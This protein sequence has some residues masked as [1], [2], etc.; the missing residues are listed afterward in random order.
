MTTLK[1]AGTTDPRVVLGL[2]GF[3]V[4]AGSA[5]MFVKLLVGEIT[6][7]QLVAGRVAIASVP[8]LVLMAI[9]GSMPKL[10]RPFLAG[11]MLLAI[12]DT[13]GPYLL[14]SWS[15][16]H[17]S[18][19]TAALVVSTMPLFTT[20]IASSTA[21]DEGMSSGA[22]LG[23]ASGFLGVGVLAG[24]EA[25][26]VTSNSALAVFAVLF[27][28]LC[29]AVGAVYSRTLLRLADPL[30]LSAVKL[31]L[32][33]FMLLPATAATDGLGAFESLSRA[34]WLG[35]ITVGFVSTGIG[36]CVYQW[37][38][39]RAGSVRA[40]L[41][42]YIVPVVALLFGWVFLDEPAG[43]ATLA[44]AVLIIVGVALVMFGPQLKSLARSAGSMLTSLPHSRGAAHR[45]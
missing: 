31:A 3:G 22:V 41:V 15:Q 21:G 13:I 10:S 12:I 14:I 1:P 39:A 32:A 11:A 6:P 35:L 40:S 37:V 25:F 18:S 16:Q 8:L 27:A 38:I 5:F 30:A 7:M 20:I 2:L 19:S 42:T 24:P 28:A 9:A 23:L 17:V 43:P 29:Y 44:G 36:R 4:T 26:D 34:G 33:T 45:F